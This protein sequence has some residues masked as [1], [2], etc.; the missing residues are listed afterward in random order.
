M[1][2]V[3]LAALVAAVIV[4][5]PLRLTAETAKLRYLVSVYLDAKEVGLKL[6]EGVAC[7][8]KGQFVVGDTGNDRLLRFTYQDKAVSGGSEIRIPELSAP[9]RVQLTSKG[10]IY[11]L[12]GK[13]R[14][15]VRLGSDGAFKGVLT[16]DG[17]PPPATIVPRS[18][19]IDAADNVYVLD[20]FS[21]RLLVLSADGQFQKAL[22]FPDGTG[23]VADLAIDF[24]G[25]V[26]LV[27]SIQRRLYSAAKDAT[28]F[29][30]LGGDLRDSLLSMATSMV[31]NRGTIFVVEGS[32]SS[33]VSFGR[34]G[35][36]LARQLTEG[37]KEG[38]LNHPGQ[39]CI[40]DR[41]EVFIADRDN[42]RIQVFGLIR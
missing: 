2:T 3:S 36:F 30:A 7:D 24:A 34:D 12:D 28:A 39:I 15:I 42:S 31:A 33:I 19:T 17:V 29:A 21:A 35:S 37:W 1:K 14:R 41:D 11:A 40:N 10:E 16:F 23:F 5:G 32:G 25:N 9:S 38:A 22:A 8:A 13:Q 26:L 27:D 6:P 4:L 18:F 20:A